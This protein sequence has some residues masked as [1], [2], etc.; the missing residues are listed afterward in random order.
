MISAKNNS[1]VVARP[2][3]AVS[4]IGLSTF[5][6]V[7]TEMLPVG[8][9]KPI[10]E[11]LGISVGIAGL[12]ISLPAL[13]AAL[14][15]P[16]I[17]LASG[18]MDRRKILCLLMLLL[19]IANIVSGISTSLTFLLTARIAVGFCMGGIWAIAGGLASRLVAPSSVGFATSI[20]FGGVAA[21]S[22]FGVPIGAF[23]GDAFG[24]RISFFCIAIFAAIVLLLLYQSLPSLP[25]SDSITLKKYAEVVVN[26]KI[27]IGL[28]I[29]L[30]IV[31][32]HFMAYTFVQPLLQVVAE[33]PSYW[34]GP[35]LFMYGIFGIIG[36]FIA[37]IISARNIILTIILISIGLTASILL[38]PILGTS[39]IGS[40]IVILLW[41]LSYGGVSVSLMTW[42]IKSSPKLIEISTSLYISFFNISISLGAFSGGYLVDKYGLLNSTLIAGFIVLIAFILIIFNMKTFAKTIAGR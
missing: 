21:A 35:I 32:G 22:V 13:F 40:S 12:M 19:V 42:M 14:F 30:F 11:T 37:G 24:W 31:S 36:N 2:W 1:H 23:I 28:L 41:G 8:L 5:A 16:L 20:I 6:V 17:I 26:K 4:S 25:I 15:A 33:F 3:F 7:T 38:F 9:L 27:I 39:Y 10:A 29:T 18:G 34:V